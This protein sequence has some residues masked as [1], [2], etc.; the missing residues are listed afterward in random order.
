MLE[1]ERLTGVP[2][3][4]YNFMVVATKSKTERIW[5]R[6]YPEDIILES[7]SSGFIGDRREVAVTLTLK[8]QA[9]KP[10]GIYMIIPNI[11]DS[12]VLKK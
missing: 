7:N 1:D 4:P 3:I 12:S 11:V 6:P 2:Y 5:E 10:Y 9:D 8:R